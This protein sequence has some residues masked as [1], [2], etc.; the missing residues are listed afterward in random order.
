M[1]VIGNDSLAKDHAVHPGRDRDHAVA[2]LPLDRHH[3]DP[4]VHDVRR[5]GLRTWNRRGARLQQRVRADHVRREHSD[6][7]GDRRGNGLRDLPGRPLP[8]G[9]SRRRRPGNRVLHHIQRRGS[10]CVGFGPD[11][12]RRHV[13]PEFLPAALVLHH[14]RAGGHRHDRRRGSRADAGARPSFSWA[15][16]SACSR[17][18]VR[19][20]AGCGGG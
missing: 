16:V 2:G 18:R 4:A 20:A 14:G 13:L 15:V 6:N 12:R 19:P 3:A 17:R 8:G 11:H 9:A 1:H 5:A 10:C 7:A